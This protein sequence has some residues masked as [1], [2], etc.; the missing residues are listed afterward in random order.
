MKTGETVLS[1]TGS[2]MSHGVTGTEPSR[3]P[4]ANWT[5]GQRPRSARST[6]NGRP[7]LAEWNGA[8][9][10]VCKALTL[11]IIRDDRQRNGVRHVGIPA[12]EWKLVDLPV[13]RKHPNLSSPTGTAPPVAKWS[14]SCLS[15]N[16]C[17]SASPHD[18]GLCGVRRGSPLLVFFFENRHATQKQNQAAIL[19]APLFIRH[20]P[21]EIVHI[22]SL[23][24]LLLEAS[25]D[26]F[27][28]FHPKVDTY[29]PSP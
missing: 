18:L 25:G 28:D 20:I 8:R 11:C 16:V 3:W 14:C 4:P 29:P 26:D 12:E 6:D 5:A 24:C 1:V 27:S 15:P 7:T 10:R 13:C 22:R 9:V 17:E 2:P 19:A 23:A 21:A